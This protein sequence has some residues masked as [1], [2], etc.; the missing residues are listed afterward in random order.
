[1]RYKIGILIIAF[2]FTVFGCTKNWDDHYNSQPETINMNVWDA[3]KG[4]PEL[5]RFVE[6][7]VKYKYDTLFQTNDTYTIFA[8][9]NAA[10]EKLLK[11]EDIGTTILNY[12]ISQHYIKPVDIQGKRK[13]QT[14]AE[15]Y[16]TFENIGGKPT[17]DG[18]VLKE[19]SPL[20]ING[21]FFV[22]GEVAF[23]RLNLYEYFTKELPY[24][25]T[26]IDKKDSIILDKEKSRPIGFDDKGN[27]VYD[28]V[29]VKYNSFEQ[30]PTQFFP[31]S[32]EFRAWTATFAFPKK[33]TYEN[34][35]SAM[36]QKLGGA[37]Q[38]YTDIPVKWQEEVL[39]PH[40]LKHGTFLNM[41]EPSEFKDISVL[42]KKKK[43][44]MVNIQGDSIVCNYV[45]TDKYLAS[46]GI[47]YDY[48]NFEIPDS[49]FSGSEKYEG[50]WL[51]YQTGANKYAWKKN[52]AVTN[53]T[54]F[55]VQKTLVKGQA[56]NDS[57]LI[58][59][60]S[61]G[62]KGVYN[63]SF[64]VRNLFPR[65][66]RMVVSTHMDIGGIYEI[67]VDNVLVKTFDYYDYVISRGLLKS[68]TGATFVPKGRYN[69]FDFWVENITD[70]GRPNIRFEYKGPGNAPGNG[71]AID[72]IEFIPAN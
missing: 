53:T 18:I 62:Y 71:L 21:K 59:N 29:A 43:F 47:V 31:V 46:N 39:I 51:A 38:D 6:L 17:I 16:S 63:V 50:E 70:Y 42:T 5:S 40:L 72:L 23:P 52:V 34:G 33:L 32:Y 56:S 55:D 27:T 12:H 35:L 2:I 37:F 3:I 67:Y 60:F 1:M 25:K 65:K 13:L 64:N 30:G 19:E 68:V 4:K 61:K 22:M 41:L 44:N 9:D 7:M 8:P 20:Y 57:I 15:K 11:T 10:I 54:S 66:Y 49:L 48:Q 26:Y 28:S 36:A 45:P 69:K 14:L 58:V 24:L